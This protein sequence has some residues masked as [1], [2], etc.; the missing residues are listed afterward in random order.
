MPFRSGIE[1]PALALP[2][3]L[4]GRDASTDPDCA[5]TS[6][7]PDPSSLGIAP[8]IPLLISGS[9]LC[10]A[11]RFPT[12]APAAISAGTLSAAGEPLHRLPPMVARP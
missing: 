8:P 4:D 10:A 3:C 11:L 6:V 5:I 2:V 7:R 1:L 12:P 9:A